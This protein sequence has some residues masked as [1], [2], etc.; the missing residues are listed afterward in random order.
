KLR[1]SVFGKGPGMA[2]YKEKAPADDHPSAEELAT[3]DDLFNR[4]SKPASHLTAFGHLWGRP[5]ESM[6]SP[7]LSWVR[8][9]ERR[10]RAESAKVSQ[11]RIEERQATFFGRDH[12]L[13][14]PYRTRPRVCSK[15]RWQP[16]VATTP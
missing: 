15:P 6:R 1:A 10:G 16:P 11:A 13:Y 7:K 4:R 12:W 9:G 2:A 5:P 3:Y 8:D 14:R